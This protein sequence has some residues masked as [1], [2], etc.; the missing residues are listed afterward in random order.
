MLNVIMHFDTL[1]MVTSLT[2]P[3]ISGSYFSGN[4]SLLFFSRNPHRVYCPPQRRLRPRE[5]ER[6]A[7]GQGQQA[8]CHADLDEGRHS[9]DPIG[10]HRYRG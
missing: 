5:T 3:P 4:K 7:G 8:Q 2:L 10:A 6:Q 1:V 9:V